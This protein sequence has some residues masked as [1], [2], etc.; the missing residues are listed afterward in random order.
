MESIKS[1][2]DGIF[3]ELQINHKEKKFTHI[4]KY[5]AIIPMTEAQY[6]KASSLNGFSKKRLQRVIA[7]IPIAEYFEME[8][9]ARESGEQ[10]TADRVKKWLSG[11]PEYMTVN[12]IDTGKDPRIIVK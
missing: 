8:R 2:S 12:A 6:A 10:V 7:E 3:T 11:H 1:I 4:T 9:L 5:D